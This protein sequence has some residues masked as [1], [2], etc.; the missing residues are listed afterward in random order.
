MKAYPA[1]LKTYNDAIIKKEK[2]IMAEKKKREDKI[3]EV[4]SHFGYLIDPKDPRFE[5]LLKVI[6]L[7]RAF[8]RI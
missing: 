8:F 2:E 7:N 4:Q 6:T 3:L 1:K 5:A